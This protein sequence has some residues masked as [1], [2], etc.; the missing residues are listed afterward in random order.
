MFR[1]LLVISLLLGLAACQTPQPVVDFDPTRDFAAYR[2]WSWQTPALHYRPDDPRLRSDLTE[3]R[4]RE[5]I[6]EALDQRGLR[7]APAG[8]PGDLSVQVWLIVDQRQQQVVTQYASPWAHPWNRGGW[9]MPG[10]YEARTVDYQVA[11]LQIDLHDGR[12]GKLVWRGSRSWVL[13][14]ADR[15]PS[16]RSE[17]YRTRAREALSGYPPR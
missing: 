10:Y 4:L 16:E 12:D 15:G 3:Q 7:P 14:S 13:S 5:A 1:R 6:A 9:A 2:S 8:A 11:T 17:L